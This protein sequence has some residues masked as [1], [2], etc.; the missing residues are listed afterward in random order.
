MRRSLSLV[1]VWTASVHVVFL[2]GPTGLAEGNSH[3]SHE[4]THAPCA[5]TCACAFELAPGMKTW[6]RRVVPTAAKPEHRVRRLFEMLIRREGLNLKQKAGHT[7]TAS[8]AFDTRRANC[9]AFAFLFVSLAR[10]VGVPAYFVS[11]RRDERTTP[12]RDKQRAQRHMAAA[13]GP[14]SNPVVIDFGGF[15]KGPSGDYVFVSDRTAAAIF[16]SNR[17]VEEL[18]DGQ[19]DP[20]LRWLRGSVR[21]APRLAVAWLNLGVALRTAGDFD[22]AERAYVLALRIDPDLSAARSNL[23]YLDHLR[24]QS[25]PGKVPRSSARV[26]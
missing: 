7:A 10:E 1:V 16:C 24:S 20:A 19:I 23:R 14:F 11:T 8:E 4:V 5:V 21:L 15:T 26:R 3:Q 13:Y 17:G 9:A 2:A 18:L 12:Y 6:V 22:A 25:L